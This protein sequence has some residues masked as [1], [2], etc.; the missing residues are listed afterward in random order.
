MATFIVNTGLG[1][2]RLDHSGS[3]CVAGGSE[4][5]MARWQDVQLD[6]LYGAFGHVL[7]LDDCLASD[8]A[9]ALISSFGKSNVQWDDQ[10]Q[11]ALDKEMAAELPEGAVP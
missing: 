11:A 3:S 2:L 10:T 6:G 7:R 5:A 4:G 9:V 1:P 8:V